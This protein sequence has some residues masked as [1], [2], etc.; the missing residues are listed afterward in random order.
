MD[1]ASQSNTLHAL[2]AEARASGADPLYIDIL[3]R[4]ARVADLLDAEQQAVEPL[5]F[6]VL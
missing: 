1:Y 6:G 5:P 2:V 4:A 3:V